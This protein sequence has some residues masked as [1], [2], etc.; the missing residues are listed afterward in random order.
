MLLPNAGKLITAPVFNKETGVLYYLSQGTGDVLTVDN[1]GGVTKS[2]AWGNSSGQPNGLAEDPDGN[3][4]V[5]DFAHAAVLNIS[6]SGEQQAVVKVYE[7]KPFKGPN[8]IVFAKDGTM[9][10]TDSGPMGETSLQYPKGGCFCI[11]GSQDGQ[12]L[13]PLALECLA[14]PS[15]L[16]L[17]PDDKMLYVCETH[18]NRLLRFFQKPTGV[19][20]FSVFVQFSGGIGPSSVVVESDGTIYVG[21]YDVTGPGRISVI[22]SEGKVQREL[23]ISDPEVTGLAIDD[24][25]PE[26]KCL[27]VTAT[28]T[29]HLYR[30]KL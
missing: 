29:D 20:H 21:H 28:K 24:T 23:T 10:F 12:I 9:F 27:Y 18:A 1:P 2:F 30:V 26:A 19:W 16:A 13:K 5:A 22:S 4:Y 3:I 14:Y 8:S 11:S 6:P 25:N 17:S 7:D 15:G